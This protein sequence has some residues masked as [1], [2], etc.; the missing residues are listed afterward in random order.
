MKVK[1]VMTQTG[2]VALFSELLGLEH[3]QVSLMLEVAP[4]ELASAGFCRVGVDGLTT[5]GRSNST[6]KEA[7]K[8]DGAVIDAM[9]DNG[10]IHA[11]LLDRQCDYILTNAPEMFDGD[12]HE[13]TGDIIRRV[14]RD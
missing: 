3:Y 2:Q 9:V 6:G 13:L 4:S 12:V 14:F 11:V 8:S 7:R 1:Y 5:W 10:E